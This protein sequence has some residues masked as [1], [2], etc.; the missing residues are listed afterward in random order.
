MDVIIYVATVSKVTQS[1][2]RGSAPKWLK[3]DPK[4][5]FSS[6]VMGPTLLS[7]FTSEMPDCSY[8][9][10]LAI[11]GEFVGNFGWMFAIL[12]EGSL[13]E[14]QDEIHHFLVFGKGGGLRRTKIVNQNVVNNLGINFTNQDQRQRWATKIQYHSFQNHY[15]HEKYYF[16]II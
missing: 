2:F 13:I 15:T 3:N 4:V 12:F 16:Q 5:T 9:C 7:H 6:I 14:I 8:F 11:F 1:D 10:L